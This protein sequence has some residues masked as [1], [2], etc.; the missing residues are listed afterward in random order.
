VNLWRFFL[1]WGRKLGDDGGLRTRKLILGVEG[2]TPTS[3]QGQ[4][5][6]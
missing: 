3:H 6:L 2:E 4:R 5:A 1:C